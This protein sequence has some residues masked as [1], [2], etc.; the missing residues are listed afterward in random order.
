MEER[1]EKVVII[2]PAD[3]N[4]AAG[5]ADSFHQKRVAAYCRVS[6]DEDEQLNSYDAQCRYYRDKINMNREWRL[7]DIFADE[8]IT[9][10]STKKREDFKKMIKLCEKGKI[11]VI[12]TKS[13]SRFARNTVDTLV[14]VR[15]LKAMGIAV[16]FEKEGIDTSKMTDE[17]LLTTMS[18]FAQ[19]ESESIS[20]NVAAGIRYTYRAGKVSYRYPIFGFTPGPDK[21]PIINEEQAVHVRAMFEMYRDGK[22]T[23]QIQDYLENNKVPTVNGKGKWCRNIIIGILRNEKYVGDVLLQKTYVADVITRKVLVNNGQLPKYLIKNAHPAIVERSLFNAVQE[24]IARRESL[25]KITTDELEQ[26]G[27]Y[28]K[29]ALTELLVCDECGTNYRRV[30]W[31]RAGGKKIVWRCV[32]RI[33]NATKYCKNSP[34]IEESLLHA[35]ILR[36]INRTINDDTALQ[37]LQ[38]VLTR[39]YCDARSPTAMYAAE[40]K[41]KELRAMMSELIDLA[42]KTSGDTDRYE[43]EFENIGRQIREYTEVYESEK[44]IIEAQSICLPEVDAIYESICQKG[45]QMHT[46]D[47]SMVRKLFD[48]IKVTP[49][50]TIKA[51]FK[52]S[53]KPVEEPIDLSAVKQAI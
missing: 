21:I 20:K 23:S 13:I 31:S 8:G 32:N 33:E 39:T 18:M 47:D 12:I 22:S 16:I 4:L 29:F 1:K 10:T 5:R 25:R 49:D 17:M 27:K 52:G 42:V 48:C 50:R 38:Q 46:F 51:Y 30:T 40:A 7:V 36:I 9:G 35:A 14:H 6:T 34:S 53:K 11:D 24:E 45:Y 43:T 44:R 26:K 15:K 28:S 2:I 19:A 41:I 37:M 3:E